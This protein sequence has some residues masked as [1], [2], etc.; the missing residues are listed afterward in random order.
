MLGTPSAVREPAVVLRVEARWLEAVRRHDARMLS[1][2]LAPIY[3]HI[4]YRGD[5]RDRDQELAAVRKPKAY[6]QHTGNRSVE[7]IQNIAIVHGLN[8]VT[9]GKTVITRLRYADVYEWLNGRWQAVFS[10]ETP[11]GGAR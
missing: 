3:I 5:V 9:H 4:N 1:A 6:V 2:V 11:V 10:Q 7:F 8:I